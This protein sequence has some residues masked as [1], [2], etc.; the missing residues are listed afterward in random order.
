MK[1]LKKLLIIDA[2]GTRA[3]IPYIEAVPWVAKFGF[4][5][6]IW[7]ALVKSSINF[8]L[9]WKWVGIKVI[10]KQSGFCCL[11]IF[12]WNCFSITSATAWILN[13]S[14]VKEI[15]EAAG[16]PKNINKYS[17]TYPKFEV[18]QLLEYS[19]EDNLQFSKL[20]QQVSN[21]H[22]VPKS[23]KQPKQKQFGRQ[24][25]CQLQLEK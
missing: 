9:V 3:T 10:C 20:V 19:P 4:S 18:L 13:L 22:L 12:H 11:S 23:S 16:L 25:V 7:V 14:E 21:N 15:I 8:S 17:F 2:A 5:F 6:T 24:V 1:I